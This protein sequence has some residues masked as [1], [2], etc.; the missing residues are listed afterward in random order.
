MINPLP[1]NRLFATLD[2]NDVAGIIAGL[3]E[4]HRANAYRI[5]F[6]TVNQ[7]SGIVD[8]TMRAYGYTTVAMT[9]TVEIDDCDAYPGDPV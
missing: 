9:E 4:E 3:P 8:D 1:K 5:Y 6:G 7:C 2:A